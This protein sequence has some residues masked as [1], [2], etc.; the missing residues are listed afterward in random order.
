MEQVA[1]RDDEHWEQVM[2]SLD[3]IFARMTDLGRTQQQLRNQ[4]EMTTQAVDG[5]GKEQQILTQKVDS[6][7]QAVARILGDQR[8]P[9]EH[10]DDNLHLQLHLVRGSLSLLPFVQRVVL[11]T[12]LRVCIGIFCPKCLFPNLLVT[13]LRSGRINAWII[14]IF[15]MCLITCGYPWPL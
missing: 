2:E 7:A 3:L 4:V 14:F 1:H 11:S 13:N 5:L 8:A 15:L 9:H 12:N 10:P 6:T